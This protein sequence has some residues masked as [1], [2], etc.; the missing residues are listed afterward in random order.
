MDAF[1]PP[2]ATNPP[3]S[4]PKRTK[5]LE[6]EPSGANP[7]TY[8]PPQ[9]TS[10][11]LHGDYNA[12]AGE[13]Q[14]G[15]GET[16][17][18]SIDLLEQLTRA[19]PPISHQ[20]IE[21]AFVPPMTYGA[22]QPGPG[23]YRGPSGSASTPPAIL[24]RDQS[25]GLLGQTPPS[26]SPALGPVLVGQNQASNPAR[27]SPTLKPRGLAKKDWKSKNA[28]DF[29]KTRSPAGPQSFTM[30]LSLPLAATSA[31]SDRLHITPIALLKL[32]SIYVPGCTIGV[33]HWIAYAMTKGRVRLI[34]RA[35]GARALLK[36]PGT[37]SVN[38]S[39]VDLVTSGNR[40]AGVTSDGGFV[41]WEVPPMVDDDIPSLLLVSVP[42]SPG[43]PYKT[44]KW[45]PTDPD[46]LA[47]ATTTEIHLINVQRIYNAHA[48][49]SI[50][51]NTLINDAEVF[52]AAPGNN[53]RIPGGDLPPLRPEQHIAAFAF[54]ASHNGLATI[55]Q[56]GTLN[57][58]SIGSQ[59]PP[60]YQVHASYGQQMSYG[61]NEQQLLWS[62]K[63]PGEGSPSSLFFMD[64]AQGMI[65]GRKRNTVI[66]LVSPKSTNVQ[67]TVKF[68]YGNGV[69][70]G[71]ASA[72]DDRDFFAHLAYDPRIRCIW[73]ASSHRSS[74]MALRVVSPEATKAGVEAPLAFEQILD[75]PILHP[76]ISLGI[77]VSSD[78]N[79]MEE[80]E[81]GSSGMDMNNGAAPGSGGELEM[82]LVAYV[83]HAGGVDQVLIGKQDLETASQAA[84]V[85]LPPVQNPPIQRQESPSIAAAAAPPANPGNAPASHPSG[86][87][88][89]KKSNAPVPVLPQ[90]QQQQQQPPPPQPTTYNEPPPSFGTS[91]PAN[92]LT[93]SQ[94][95]GPMDSNSPQ[96]PRSPVSEVEPDTAET[97]GDVRSG[98]SSSKKGRRGRDRKGHHAN[99]DRSA[100]AAGIASDASS[101]IIREIQK[102]EDG[103]QNKI[104]TVVTKEF[105]DQ[106]RRLEQ[107]HEQDR[108][109]AL[110]FQDRLSKNLSTELVKNS[111]R[112]FE[113]ALKTEVQRTIL[114]A[115]EMITKNEVRQAL[116]AQIVRGISESMN[117]TL[118][119]EIERL[120]LRP[121]VSTHVART[122][123]SAV[124]PLIERHVKESITRVLI[125]SYQDSTSEMYDQLYREIN[126][127]ILNLKKE[128]VT[129]QSEALKGQES[130]LREMELSIRTL[131]DQ[132]KTLTTQRSVTPYHM[133]SHRS[134]PAPIPAHLR[135]QPPAPT[136]GQIDKLA[137]IGAWQQM[138]SGLKPEAPAPQ[139]LANV[140]QSYQALPAPMSM[141]PQNQYAPPPQQLPVHPV[142]APLANVQ[143]PQYRHDTP[144]DWEKVFLQALSNSDIRALRETLAHCP[145]DKVM[146][147]NGPLLVGQTIILSVIH[148]LAGCLADVETMDESISLLWWLTRASQVLDAHDRIIH[149]YLDKMLPNIQ[150]NL[151]RAIPRFVSAGP[152]YNRQ[153][154][155]LLQTLVIKAHHQ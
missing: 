128:I 78:A 7:I 97:V 43:N 59:Q 102:V 53:M 132:V 109:N 76:T 81:R 118:P 41:V 1:Q 123:S 55:S 38:S 105:R 4:L 130:L 122:F 100:E 10:S 144:E 111:G 148:K 149:D 135:Q 127:E 71:G 120:L 45:H 98:E 28:G 65:V 110:E 57:L 147:L 44:I 134:S 61:Q 121:D 152:Q 95:Y 39:I 8:N 9:T 77:L 64:Q 142:P 143:M 87:R 25:P 72:P 129:W 69:F 33:S 153:L 42:P 15:V 136:H 84:L 13:S 46:L 27:A 141:P 126:E 18:K 112:V 115:I 68:V 20:P 11:P 146:P 106:Q 56:E 138:S 54:D 52:P 5:T 150:E 31:S 125:P 113:A 155:D 75:F 58:W 86:P 85:K 108:F 94:N 116:D 145:A 79:G 83:I 104:S 140:P 30:D 70:G 137:S 2:S 21:S 96:R 50:T 26:T 151:F 119:N 36:L 63:I 67:A 17:R 117:H 62:G 32:E 139:P 73:A 74:L 37:F 22:P 124:T 133:Q 14:D 51:Q 154:S 3:S 48:G 49:D 103:L 40:L 91:A 114:P 101:N 131:T 35:N 90:Q 93:P 82:A 34:A 16:K 89:Q 29:L 99:Q 92:L 60:S 80:M 107:M 6:S 47:L 23:P 66:Q 24:P 88:E 19:A 12:S